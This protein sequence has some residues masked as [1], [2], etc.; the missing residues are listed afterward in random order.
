MGLRWRFPLWVPDDDLDTDRLKGKLT[1][2]DEKQSKM[3][4]EADAAVLSACDDWRT[5]NEV[6]EAT[7]FGRGRVNRAIARLRTADEL[8][9]D[10]QDR[11]RNP[12]MEVF[13]RCQV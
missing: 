5:R 2:A 3:D 12:K 6:V 13:K 8:C 11:P 7:G 9:E 4:D 1:R 10:K